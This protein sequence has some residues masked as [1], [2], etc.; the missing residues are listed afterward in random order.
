M[1]LQQED[2]VDG[3][4]ELLV[5]VAGV[6]REAVGTDLTFEPIPAKFGT[7]AKIFAVRVVQSEGDLIE[8]AFEFAMVR[9]V[10]VAMSGNAD[11]I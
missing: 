4:H 9:L 6:I 8:V 10:A 2:E 11:A 5:L 1:E 7:D 3:S